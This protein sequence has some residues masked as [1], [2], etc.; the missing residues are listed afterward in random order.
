MSIISEGFEISDLM[1]LTAFPLLVLGLIFLS[2]LISGKLGPLILPFPASACDY[3]RG[4]HSQMD[5]GSP[6]CCYK[7]GKP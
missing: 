3:R 2:D 7:E 5:T 4:S 1:V 6:I